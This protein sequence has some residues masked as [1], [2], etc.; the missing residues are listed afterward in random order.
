M[1]IVV[2]GVGAVI[3]LG[4]VKTLRQCPESVTVIGVDRNLDAFGKRRCDHFVQKPASEEGSAYLSFWHELLQQYSVDMVIPGIEADV[5]FF[6][7]HR[8]DFESSS[9]KVVLNSA[10]LIR[11][12]KDKWA[13]YERL[14]AAGIDA[15]PGRISGSWDECV[16]ELGPAP[17]LMKPRHGSGGRGMVFLED[18]ADFDYWRSKAGESFMVQRVVGSDD[19][20]Y[21]VSVFG[22]GDGDA[23]PAAIMR[24]TLGPVGTTWWAQTVASSLPIEQMT[25]TLN[26]LLQPEG[27]TN[28]QFRLQDETAL[29]LEVNPRISAS[30]S[31]RAELG[32]NEAW[33]CI[34]HYLLRRS[35]KTNGLR[36]GQAWR[37]IADEVAAQ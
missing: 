25:V 16:A 13:T 34:E 30:T 6:D 32:V 36:P 33:M 5:F 26:R 3:G 7:E 9:A 4:I 22:Y 1:N 20:E 15:I 10:Q 31:L 17:L 21:T 35:I 23:T 19:Q 8:H 24:R 28:Y 29:L 12:G 2:T 37:Y 27:P 18:E 14:K 11:L